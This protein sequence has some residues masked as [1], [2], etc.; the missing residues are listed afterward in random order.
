MRN[1]DVRFTPGD[2][3]ERKKMVY[4]Y[5]DALAFYVRARTHPIRKRRKIIIMMIKEI[6][7]L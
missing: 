2:R 4:L 6:S 3:R 5:L 7:E 1:D